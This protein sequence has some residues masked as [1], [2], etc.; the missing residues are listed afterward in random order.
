MSDLS[1][2]TLGTRARSLSLAEL[3]VGAAIVIAH[4][5]YHIVPNEVPILFVL[6]ILSIRFREGS[7]AAIGLTRPKS[8]LRTVAFGAIIAVVVITIGQFVTE[9]LAKNLGLHEN[10]RAAANAL[11]PLAGHAWNAAK[12]LFLVWTFAAFGE[13]ISYRRYLLGRAADVGNKTGL[14]YWVALILVSILFGFGHVY[15]GPAGV[16]TT[17]CD[18]FMIGTAY[19]LAR[20][21][22]WVAVIAHGLTDTIGIAL[23]FFGLAD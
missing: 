6:G 13:E 14:S 18:G 5:V 7:F 19:L 16:F 9:P 23:L 2:A 1:P 21:N 12:A 4:N 22:L 20:R 8:W 11:G 10:A 15:Q 17:G 3:I